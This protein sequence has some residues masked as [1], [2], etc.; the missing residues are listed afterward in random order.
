MAYGKMADVYD[1]LMAAAPYDQWIEMSLKLFKQCDKPVK[2]VIDLGCGTGEI[3]VRLA[4]A[5]FEVTGVDYSSDMLAYAERKATK[6][7]TNIDLIQQDLRE[8]E[9]LKEMDAAV[10]YCDV[11][12]YLTS[13]SDLKNVVKRIADSLKPGGVF[14][15]DVHSMQQVENNFIDHTFA[16]VTEDTSYIWFCT[17]GENPGEMYHDLTFFHRE[18]NKY[19]RFDEEHFQRTYPISF[20]ER[21]LLAA[22]FQNIKIYGDFSI[23]KEITEETERVFFVAQKRVG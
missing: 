18:G 20:Y 14:I 12:N 4:K 10:C 3:S 21:L 1:T 23:D 8:L 7:Y 19:V 6:E 17:G 16:E 9:G 5:G 15:F 13:E 2:Q 22:G 11:M